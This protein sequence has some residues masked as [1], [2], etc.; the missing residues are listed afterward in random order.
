MPIAYVP[1]LEAIHR[2]LLADLLPIRVTLKQSTRVASH[3][4]P[5]HLSGAVPKYSIP[6]VDVV[7]P[8]V[9]MERLATWCP[10][11]LLKATPWPK[12]WSL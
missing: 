6:D 9:F 4:L 7:A 8:T 12:I 5:E 2:H 1:L 11:R 3:Q 10:G